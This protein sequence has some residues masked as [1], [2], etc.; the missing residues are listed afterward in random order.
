M[1]PA[2]RRIITGLRLLAGIPASTFKS[3]FVPA[4]FL[5]A[6]GFLIRRGR[7]LAVPPE[8]ILLLNE[9]LGYFV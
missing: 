1:D 5:L 8:K 4:D 7:N 2:Q 6:E 3:F 9:I